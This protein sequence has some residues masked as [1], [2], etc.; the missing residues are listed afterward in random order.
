MHFL[1]VDSLR[2]AGAAMPQVIDHLVTTS[3]VIFV[4]LGVVGIVLLIVRDRWFGLLLLVLGSSTS[5][6]TPTTWATCRTT[7]C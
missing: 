1:S 7:C 4:L 5:A 6:S 2:A 3:N